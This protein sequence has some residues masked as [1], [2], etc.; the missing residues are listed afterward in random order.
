MSVINIFLLYA[1]KDNG[2]EDELS[3]EQPVCINSLR[4]I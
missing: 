1:G 2:V 3:G 4:E